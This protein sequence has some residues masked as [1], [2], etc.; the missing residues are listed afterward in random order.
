MAETGR[1]MDSGRRKAVGRFLAAAAGAAIVSSDLLSGPWRKIG[2]KAIHTISTRNLAPQSPRGH[3]EAG[4]EEAYMR[5]LIGVRPWTEL[6]PLETLS[7]PVGTIVIPMDDQQAERIVVFGFVHSL[8]RHGVE[9]FRIIEP[10]NVTLSTTLTPSGASYEGGVFLVSAEDAA[11]VNSTKAEADFVNVTTTTLTSAF[12]SNAVFR[13]RVPTVILVIR[14]IWGR[15]DITLERMKIRGRHT[16]GPDPDPRDVGYTI[17]DQSEIEADPNILKGYS[18]IVD[19]CPGWFGHVPDNIANVIREH[20]RAGNEIIFTDIAFEDID[21]IFPDVIVIDER[22]S[23]P[24]AFDSVVHNP[25]IPGFKPEFPS[26]YYNDPPDPNNIKIYTPGSGRNVRQIAA[27]QQSNVRILADSPKYHSTEPRATILAF[28]F[29]EGV[30]IVEGLGFHPQ[31]QR[32][33]LVGNKG[34]YAVHQF[35]G[36]KFVHGVPPRDFLISAVPEERVI[37]Q[38]QSTTYDVTITSI[39][40]FD[41]AVTLTV[42]GLPSGATATFNPPAPQ[43][44]PG[45]TAGS[46]MTVA[47]TL[48]TPVGTYTLAITG[49]SGELI[50]STT[51]RLIVQEAPGDFSI[52]ADPTT[53]TVPRRE[54]RTTTITISPIGS[55]DQ[56]VSLVVSGLPEDTTGTFDPVSVTPSPPN[57]ANSVLTVC[58]GSSAEPG[59]YPLT[60]TGTSG[61]LS[62]STNVTLIIPEPEA[63]SFLIL[64][65]LLLGLLGLLLGLLAALLSRK[66]AVRAVLRR[67]L[68]V[69]RYVAPL[70]M[71]GCFYCRRLIPARAVYCP[72]CGRP[73]A[74]P[75]PAAR[76]VPRVPVVP[77]VAVAPRRR[78]IIGF[79]LALVGGV[80]ILLNA[81]FLLSAT[82]WDV[83]ADVFTWLNIIGQSYAFL[84]GL[85]AGLIVIIGAILILIGHPAIAS[86]AIVPLAVLS[87]LIG[88]GF[89]AGFILA[90]TGALLSLVRR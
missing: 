84:I 3:V 28:Y 2:E 33:D 83:F 4:S 19:D 61:S 58:A 41:S 24:G 52:A 76:P 29:V 11:Q 1:K 59:T 67:P 51:V 77:V 70:P 45:G 32:V 86:I 34:F 64:I 21:T 13:V 44:P 47:T 37:Q 48:S 18:L 36:N 25:P 10:P 85:I 14:G 39:T 89:I 56:P 88:G 80:L 55:F 72:F 63:P 38:G 16:L 78:P 26:Q 8:L 53:I 79:A 75:P 87:L 30:G 42:S 74:P 5:P 68:A 27:A 73:R 9:I 82:F 22:K 31:E 69:P 17:L 66:K 35:Y 71:V 54:C 46:V 57:S 50:R 81:S 65:P 90:I 43:P 12:T 23:K 15:T 40:A 6:P 62:H 7:F 20:T 60:V 49:T